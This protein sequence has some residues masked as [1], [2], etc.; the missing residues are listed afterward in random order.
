MKPDL[1]IY[2]GN[3]LEILARQLARI[4]RQ[5]LPSPLA[6]EIIVVQSRGMQRWV[7]MALARHNGICANCAFPFPNA[8]LQELFRKL[9]PDLPDQSL[10][11]P[12]ALTFRIMKVLPAG[13]HW[14]GMSEPLPFFPESSFEYAKRVLIKKQVHDGYNCAI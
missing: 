8:F 14:K 5:P 10:F 11:D 12:A 6:P 9:I 3:R 13:M 2:A 7:S 4:V 1:N